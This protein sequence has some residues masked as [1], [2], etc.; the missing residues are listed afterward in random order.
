MDLDTVVYDLG[1]GG[2]EN[3]AILRLCHIVLANPVL[4]IPACKI[5]SGIPRIINGTAFKVLSGGMFLLTIAPMARQLSG[6]VMIQVN[7]CL[8]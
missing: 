5:E 7:Y 4:F 1:S 3:A 6:K 8:I 2:S